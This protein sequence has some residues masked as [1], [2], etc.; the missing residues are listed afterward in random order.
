MSDWPRGYEVWSEYY[1]E[2]PEDLHNRLM[3][4]QVNTVDEAWQELA[5]RLDLIAYEARQELAERPERIADA[6]ESI[7]GLFG[8]RIDDLGGEII[9]TKQNNEGTTNE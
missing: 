6:I 5:E 7:V 1:D 3:A 4:E 2:D 9:N 8:S